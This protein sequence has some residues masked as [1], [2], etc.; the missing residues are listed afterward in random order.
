MD[1][2]SLN[3]RLSG[4][5]SESDRLEEIERGAAWRIRYERRDEPV[6]EVT[7]RANGR[8]SKAPAPRPE[9]YAEEHRDQNGEVTT[10]RCRVLARL[11]FLV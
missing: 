2:A 8:Q 3:N 10:R 11:T 4:G 7:R 5:G 9:N 6:R 1:L